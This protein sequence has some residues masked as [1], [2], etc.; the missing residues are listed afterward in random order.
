M[1]FKI[2]FLTVSWVD[3]LDVV[4]VSYVFYRL[5]L[6]MRGTIASQIFLGF[7]LIFA[8]SFLAQALHLTALGWLL[9]TLTEVWVIAFIVL[10]QPELRR[11][12]IIVGRSRIVR[13]FLKL[14]VDESINEVVDA[15]EEMAEKQHGALIV[16][17]R[18]MG[19]R[20]FIETGIQ[21][22]A[23]VTKQLLLSIFNP[24][25]PLHDGAVIIKDRVIEAARCTLPLSLT[26]TIGGTVLG[27]R[28]RAG[29]GVTEQADVVSVIVSEET[30]TISV[31]DNGVLTRNLTSQ[32]LR[33]WLKESLLVKTDKSPKSIF[34]TVR[35]QVG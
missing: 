5:F 4:I 6:V 32:Q 15:V 22:Q 20:I 26:T 30:G 3:V 21:L 14:D 33:E 17:I 16:F 25:S 34:S 12:L 1:L 10:F 13:M 11:L 7:I 24:K 35:N 19:L 2:G 29:L 8:F 28:H 18:A 31:A 23:R 27:M 9:R